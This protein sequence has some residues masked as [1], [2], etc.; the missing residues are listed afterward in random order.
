MPAE[1][2]SLRS[3][4]RSTAGQG[5]PPAG[6]G[7]VTGWRLDNV[8]IAF[9]WLVQPSDGRHFGLSALSDNLK[10]LTQ[11]AQTTQSGQ[12]RRQVLAHTGAPGALGEGALVR[13]LLRHLDRASCNGR[14]ASPVRVRTCMPRSL[15]R[16][17]TWAACPLG[18]GHV[19]RPLMQDDA[20][21][22]RDLAGLDRTSVMH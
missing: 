1:A 20:G 11:T 13:T 22:I 14:A 19:S 12:R 3:E 9:G 15:D 21:S 10:R 7:L 16:G 6:D 18:T 17:C 2:Y 4:Q 8:W 5:T